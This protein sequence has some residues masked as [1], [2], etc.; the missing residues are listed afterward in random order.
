ML[1]GGGLGI[2]VAF[3][4]GDSGLLGVSSAGTFFGEGGR[5]LFPIGGILSGTGLSLCFIGGP[6]GGGG[7][8]VGG[9]SSDEPREKCEY[10]IIYIAT[11]PK[12]LVKATLYIWHTLLCFPYAQ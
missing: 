1:G 9:S 4:I 5:N 2:L 7:A 10:Q 12:L 8:L 3:E 11:T 6:G